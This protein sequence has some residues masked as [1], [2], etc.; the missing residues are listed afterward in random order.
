[1]KYIVRNLNMHW[2]RVLDEGKPLY[3]FVSPW[4]KPLVMGAVDEPKTFEVF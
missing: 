3:L 4:G 1:M 2:Q